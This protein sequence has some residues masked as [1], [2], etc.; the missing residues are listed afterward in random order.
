M[1]GEVIGATDLFKLW[2]AWCDRRNIEPGSQKNFGGKMKL[3]F[4]WESN[5]KRPRYLGIRR[6]QAVVQPLRLAVVN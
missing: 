4:P 3:R 1:D 5:N 6:K 2:Q